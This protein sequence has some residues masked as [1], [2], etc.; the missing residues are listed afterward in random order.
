MAGKFRIFCDECPP[1]ANTFEPEEKQAP[2]LPQQHHAA[3]T[4][5]AIAQQ[6][7]QVATKLAAT[8]AAGLISNS[9]FSSSSS[10]ISNHDQQ[11]KFTTL[12]QASVPA[13]PPHH[14]PFTR[15]PLGIKREPLGLRQA[16]SQA[17]QDPS[18]GQA[19]LGTQASSQPSVV[20]DED[21]EN[22]I[23]MASLGSDYVPSISHDDDDLNSSQESSFEVD[24]SHQSFTREFECDE[25]AL[26]DFVDE[27][28]DYHLEDD[29]ELQKELSAAF[30]QHDDS[31]LFKSTVYIDDIQSYLKQLE[32]IPDLRPI[33]NY[34]DFQ[35]DIS[36]EKRT[37]LIKWLI[38]VTDEY[39]LQSETLFICVNIIDR[40]LSKHPVSTHSLQLLG[41]AAMFIASKYEEIYPP[42][43]HQFV[44]V[45]D[46]SCSGKEICQ[47]EQNILKTLNFRISQPSITFFLNQIFA[48]NKFTKKVYHLA[49]YLCF[50][51]LLADKPF[52][53]YYPSEIALA[54]VILAAQQLDGAANISPELRVAYDKSNIDQLN[55]RNLP[56]GVKLRD[57]DRRKYTINKQ[58]PFCIESLRELQH[59]AYTRSSPL[60]GDSAVVIRFSE[61]SRSCVATLPPPTIEDLYFY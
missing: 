4:L 18:A 41:V 54:A 9:N 21:R 11:D 1:R 37:I 12:E 59:C 46:E 49:E 25:S 5:A 13:A 51:S 28:D 14:G 36:S 33:P 60:N 61:E 27:H 19:N 52:L 35:N 3:S 39:R 58:L 47:M 38:E 55:R 16:S 24:D 17:Q 40:F 43:L 45:T 7:Q 53:E 56:K 44:E 15:Q 34:M 42:E 20:G 48:F 22:D 29:D 30:K 2:S 31:Q 26:T 8:N 23:S 50:L 32:R 57:V 10:S 6:Q